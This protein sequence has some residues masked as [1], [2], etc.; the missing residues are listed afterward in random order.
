MY[1]LASTLFFIAG[2]I[3]IFLNNDVPLGSVMIV[4]G[5]TFAMLAV[6][7]EKDITK[8]KDEIDQ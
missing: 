5:I 2:A 1:T 8:K 7:E 4:L 6:Y 3:H